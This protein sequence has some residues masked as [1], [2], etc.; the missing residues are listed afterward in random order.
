MFPIFHS[1]LHKST[2]V[3]EEAYK[4]TECSAFQN[5][6]SASGSGRKN[7]KYKEHEVSVV[8]YCMA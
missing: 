1:N 3:E 8:V 6:A 2:A 7:I 5:A 4:H